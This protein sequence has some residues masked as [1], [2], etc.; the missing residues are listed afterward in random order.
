M[1]SMETKILK[2]YFT[3]PDNVDSV[4][5]KTWKVTWE[6]MFNM[7]DTEREYMS[8][9]FKHIQCKD[10]YKISIQASYWH[11]CQPRYTFFH[12]SMFWYTHMELW[13]PNQEDDLINE[14]AE[15]KDNKTWTVYAN[16]PVEI[17]ENLLKKHWWII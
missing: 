11:Y 13:Y 1:L 8:V 2:K 6:E 5:W 4:F 7:W 3:N 15:D 9:I 14:Y 12:H 17:I 10:W 16:V